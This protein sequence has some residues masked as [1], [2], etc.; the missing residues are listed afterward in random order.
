MRL[1]LPK[2]HAFQAL[3]HENFRRYWVAQLISLVGSWMQGTA[4][5][6]LVL[7]LFTN[8]AEATAHLGIVSALQFAPS[9]VLALFAG[10]ILDRV[11]RK[12]VMIVTQSVLLTTAL[13]LA[14]LVATGTVTFAAVAII[15][16]TSGLANAFDMPAR[17]AIVPSLVP[18]E[19]MRN[20]V[21]LNSLSFNVA[22]IAGAALFGVLSPFLGLAPIFYLNAASFPF[23]IFAIART[24][25]PRI[26]RAG[27]NI[28]ED[29]RGGLSYVWRTPIVRWTILTLCWLSITVIN[30]N[31]IIPSFAK[32]ALGLGEA[33]YG[34]LSAAFG[35]GAV[36]GAIFQAS[37][38][39][40]GSAARLMTPGALLLTFAVASL[41]LTPNAPTA[42][43][44]LMAAGAGMILFLVAANTTVQLTVPEALRGRV[45]SVYTLVFAGMS[46]FGALLCGGLMSRFGPRLGVLVVAALGLLIV[47]LYPRPRATSGSTVPQ[48]A[49]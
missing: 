25:I 9:L 10:A 44:Q 42:A 12:A 38:A 13:L 45:M 15:A 39:A 21:A 11:S 28:V 48:P 35:V 8:P 19:S 49:D 26:E 23:V 3:E 24:P 2:L 40:K 43:L 17:Q 31:I 16:F 47:A 33:G 5:A 36:L 34:L 30:F 41:Y 4:Q 37:S 7:G 6:W 22:R 1:A 20:A 18:R 29:I 46:P 27:S 32:T 14:T